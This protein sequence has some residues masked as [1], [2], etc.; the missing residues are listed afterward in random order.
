MKIYY[1]LFIFLIL[2][3]ASSN[4]VSDS[5]IVGKYS[6][7][8]VYGVG[9]DIEFKEDKTF[10]YTW[11]TGLLNGTT[12]G[13]WAVSGKKIILDS[14]RKKSDVIKFKILENSENSLD[15]YKL[16]FLDDN[17]DILPKV[18]CLFLKESGEMKEL[19]AN[20]DGELRVSKN[21]DFQ[22]VR[23]IFLGFQEFE[24]KKEDLK[25]N[26]TLMMF[27]KET[28]YQYFE[29]EVMIFKGD[30]IYTDLIKKTRHVKN[31]F[32]TKMD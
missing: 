17:K 20:F 6:Y 5:D 30:K 25:G 3:C 12:E 28:Y 23:F 27:Q 26:V 8:G 24:I 15:F 11:V 31:D 19:D 9:S 29:N 18:I 1:L 21:E 16:K 32:F 22:K 13:T 10:T 7:K 4:K 2:G 14:D